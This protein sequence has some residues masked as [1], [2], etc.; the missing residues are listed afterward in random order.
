MDRTEQELR[1]EYFDGPESDYKSFAQFLLDKGFPDL[2]NKERENIPKIKDGG[3]VKEK[4]K[5]KS[6][7]ARKATRGTKFRGVR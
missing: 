2:A 6:R 5:N 3:Y 4:A 7:G 1:E